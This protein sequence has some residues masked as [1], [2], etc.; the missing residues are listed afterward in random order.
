M[1]ILPLGDDAPDP[2]QPTPSRP[3]PLQD[4][5]HLLVMGF[6]PAERELIQ[7]ITA[8]SQRRHLRI[9]LSGAEHMEEADVILLDGTD[10]KVMT[11]AARGRMPGGKVVIQ[12]DGQ[13][14]PGHIHLQRPIQWPSLPALLQQALGLEAP[15]SSRQP[16]STF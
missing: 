14:L 10:T 13:P 9:E 7:G 2:A 12:V 8:L 16:L 11:W 3:A 1:I 4:T 15:H 6:T 5:V